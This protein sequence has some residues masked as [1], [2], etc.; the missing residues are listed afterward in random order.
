M[1]FQE[2][3]EQA[4]KAISETPKPF[5]PKITLI[6]PGQWRKTNKKRMF[7]KGKCP[8]GDIVQETDAGLTVLFNA[9]DVLAFCVANGVKIQVEA[10]NA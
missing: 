2:L 6:M 10:T 9:V 1:T 4:I 5:E 3:A 7:P 8:V